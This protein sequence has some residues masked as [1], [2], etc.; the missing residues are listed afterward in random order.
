MMSALQYISCPTKGKDRMMVE[1]DYPC[2]LGKSCHNCLFAH[3]T[4]EKKFIRN[5]TGTATIKASATMR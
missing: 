3:H 4:S 1:M 5:L 2:G